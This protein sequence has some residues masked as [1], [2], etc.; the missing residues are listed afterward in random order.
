MAFEDSSDVASM[1]AFTSRLEKRITI[2][3]ARRMKVTQG[4]TRMVCYV[5]P[6]ST[7]SGENPDTRADPA[8]MPFDSVTAVLTPN[9]A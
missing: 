7:L 9:G 6:P 2:D 1:G 5:S 8:H 4:T 3:K